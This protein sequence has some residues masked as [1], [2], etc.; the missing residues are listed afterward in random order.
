MQSSLHRMHELI[1]NIMLHAKSRLGGGISILAQPDAP[2]VSAITQVVDEIRFVSADHDI[3]V[4]LDVNRPVTCDP[5]RLA[6]AVS[7]LVTNAI[8]HGAPRTPVVVRGWSGSNEIVIEVINQGN[9]IAEDAQQELFQPSSRG[10]APAAL[11]AMLSTHVR[12]A[13]LW[14]QPTMPILSL[15][16]CDYRVRCR[17]RRSHL[18]PDGSSS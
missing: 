8:K 6:Q 13:D 5:A 17:F 7:N 4:E 1:E 16:F 10:P 2:L 18:T 14:H 9:A 11:A 3:M 15:S 12:S